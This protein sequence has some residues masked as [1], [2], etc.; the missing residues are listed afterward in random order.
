MEDQARSTVLTR[1]TSGGASSPS[2]TLVLN[3][4]MEAEASFVRSMAAA[5]R[6]GHATTSDSEG[7]RK[8]TVRVWLPAVRLSTTHDLAQGMS[9]APEQGVSSEE[10]GVCGGGGDGED[11]GFD[12]GEIECKVL[13]TVTPSGALTVECDVSMPEHWPVIPRRVFGD[14]ARYRVTEPFVMKGYG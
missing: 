10:G 12:A 2:R 9:L 14:S 6:L 7:S 1:S 13:Y 4:L 11:D 3:G 8:S 5:W